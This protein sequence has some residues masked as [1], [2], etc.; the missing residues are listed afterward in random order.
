MN[1]ISRSTFRAGLALTL[2]VALVL[3]LMRSVS[4]QEAPPSAPLRLSLGE[5]ARMA[6][7]Q[8][9]LVQGAQYRAQEAEARVRQRRSELLPSLSADLVQGGRSFNTATLGIDFP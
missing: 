9:A 6:A 4:A 7:R 5:A 8:S 1:S 2:V 3:F